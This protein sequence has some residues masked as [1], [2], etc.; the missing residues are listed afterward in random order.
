MALIFGLGERRSVQEGQVVNF[1]RVALIAGVVGMTLGMA[2]AALAHGL[3]ANQ[4]KPSLVALGDS[5]T[6]G[7]N[8]GPNNQHPSR[9]AFPY[10]IG[11]ADGLR[12]RDLGVPGWSSSDLLN[13]LKTEKYAQAIRHANVIAVDI[14]STDLLAIALKDGLLNPT[15]PN[16]TLTA[17][18]EAQF[19]Q[20]LATYAVNLPLILQQIRKLN[21]TAT[22]LLYN[23]YNPIPPQYPGLYRIAN[24]V[25]GQM[26]AIIATTAPVY[27]KTLLVNDYVAFLGHTSQYILPGDVHPTVAGQEELATLGE[28]VMTGNP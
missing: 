17:Q 24:L 25:I 8:L 6:F 22:I 20:A 11:Q 9:E 12:V 28:A 5:I 4:G 23:I 21:P 19:V 1:K 13:A 26:D 14:G 16:P 7:Y 10:L 2:P 27:S 18:E 15:D 3:P